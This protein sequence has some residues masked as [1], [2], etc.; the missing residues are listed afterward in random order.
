MPFTRKKV[1]GV[2]SGHSAVP[3][4]I[5]I[6]TP[7]GAEIAANIIVK[8]KRSSKICRKASPQVSQ[9]SCFS[10]IFLC[11]LQLIFPEKSQLGVLKTNIFRNSFDFHVFGDFINI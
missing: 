11:G 5:Q 10:S 9:K 8:I 2:E 7:F 3:P 6:P 1:G 4:P